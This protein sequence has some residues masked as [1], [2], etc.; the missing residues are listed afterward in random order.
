MYS[1]LKLEIFTPLQTDL[2]LEQ[3]C[4]EFHGLGPGRLPSQGPAGSQE[5]GLSSRVAPV[6]LSPAFHQ[7]A[8]QAK[9]TRGCCTDEGAAVWQ[10]V[11][12]G[13][14]GKGKS[15]YIFTLL[16]YSNLPPVLDIVYLLS[17]WKS[18]LKGN[19]NNDILILIM[20][21]FQCL[22]SYF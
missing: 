21:L 18:S 15:D 12:H 14:K 22:W 4:E 20:F 17:V 2:V 13:L 10:G 3:V 19:Y 8:D 11:P 16:Q 7:Q 6:D 1:E 9:L 5:S